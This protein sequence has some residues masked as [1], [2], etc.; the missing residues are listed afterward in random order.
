MVQ[1]TSGLR[2][3]ESVVVRAFVP[4]GAFGT[5]SRTAGAGTP[6]RAVVAGGTGS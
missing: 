6:Q 2:A 1:I 4:G 3:G 5:F